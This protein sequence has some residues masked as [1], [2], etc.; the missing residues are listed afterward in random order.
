MLPKEEKLYKDKNIEIGYFQ[1]SFE[2]HVLII[3]QETQFILQRGVLEELARTSRDTLLLKLNAIDPML[4]Y[5]L[6]EEK[7]S[8]DYLQ[9]ALAQAHIKE[10][11][12]FNRNI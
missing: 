9:V 12:E 6:N 7:I 11:D 3:N 10:L 4:P 5:T 1:D 2:D 8:A